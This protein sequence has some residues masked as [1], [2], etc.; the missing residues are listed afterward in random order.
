MHHFFFAYH[1]MHVSNERVFISIS[2]FFS[3]VFNL[4][5]RSAANAIPNDDFQMLEDNDY[6]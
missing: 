4:D 1:F 3:F 5:Y 6:Y 2:F